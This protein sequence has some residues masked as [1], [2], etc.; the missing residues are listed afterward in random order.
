MLPQ[1]RTVVWDDAVNL[2]D[3]VTEVFRRHFGYTR[4]HAEALMLEV[5]HRGRAVVS[6]GLRERMEAD[7]LA[8]HSYGLRA[9]LERVE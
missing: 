1:W 2:M 7:V 4:A 6:T 5:H 3:Y 8:M 9:T